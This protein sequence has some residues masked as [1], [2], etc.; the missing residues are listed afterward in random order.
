MTTNQI[1][2]FPQKW[3]EWNGKFRST[4][5][6]FLRGDKGQVKDLAWRLTGS[7]DLYETTTKY[8]C[9]S[10]NFITCND[11]FTLHD[12]FSYNKKHNNANGENN[13]DGTDNNYSVNC[14]VEGITSNTK[15]QKLRNQ[16]I[17]NG[18]CLL[19]F[20]LGTP[21]ILGGDEIGRTHEGNNNPYCQDNEISWFNWDML[22]TRKDIFLFCSKAIAFRK[23]YSILYK[24][25]FYS[26]KDGDKDTVPDIL[27]FDQ[28]LHTPLWHDPDQKILCYQIDGSEV[29]SELGNYHLF[30]ILNG[31]G[32][33]CM[34]SIPRN[35]GMKWYRIV[36]TSLR[37]GSDFFRPGKEKVLRNQ[38][39]YNTQAHSIVV[40]LGKEL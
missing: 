3:S 36:D 13:S 9:N 11:G 8:P 39:T 27:W 29:A 14:G 32:G 35:P 21:M 19:F 17:K 25:Q 26:G 5:R 31:G 10:I 12:L 20:S 1:G 6:R 30:F 23:R 37:P 16:M 2:N 18:L 4:V 40:L 34:V 22:K 24:K 33:K 15:I 7:A 38:H 28:N